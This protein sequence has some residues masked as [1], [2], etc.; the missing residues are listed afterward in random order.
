MVHK[1]VLRLINNRTKTSSSI[2]EM[3]FVLDKLDPNLDFEILFFSIELKLPDLCELK[4][5]N[6]LNHET[7]GSLE[8]YLHMH[9]A[10]CN[11]Y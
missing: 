3:L 1:K 2:S 8:Y 4:D 5:K 11:F 9:K 6:A 7:R 10:K